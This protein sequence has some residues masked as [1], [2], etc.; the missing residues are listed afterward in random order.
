MNSADP[1]FWEA[2]I[3]DLQAELAAFDFYTEDEVNRFADLYFN[4]K[5]TQDKLQAALAPAIERFQDA[6]LQEQHDFRHKLNHYTRT[7]AFVA[8][9]I[10]FVDTDL[11]KLYQFARFLLR[12]LPLKRDQLPVEIQQNIAIE[13]YRIQQTSKGK[14]VLEC[15]TYEIAPIRSKEYYNL[16]PEDKEVE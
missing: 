15:D 9:I 11:E 3:Y 13:S 10:S 16:A 5:S 4:P 6:L 1:G 14:V 12:K 2:R 7:Y 8:Q